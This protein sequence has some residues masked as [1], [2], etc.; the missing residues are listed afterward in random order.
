MEEGKRK[1]SEKGT[2]KEDKTMD[3]C[4]VEGAGV[5]EVRKGRRVGRLGLEGVEEGSSGLS[6]VAYSVETGAR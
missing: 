2:S 4:K 5:G 6:L 3:G 1:N